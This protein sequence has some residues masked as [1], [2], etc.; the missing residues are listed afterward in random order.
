VNGRGL[1]TKDM[2][3]SFKQVLFH[4]SFELDD[5]FVKSMVD[6]ENYRNQVLYNEAHGWKVH[7]IEE[8]ILHYQD[9]IL[10]LQ[11]LFSSPKV[12]KGFKLRSTNKV[13]DNNERAYSTPT[14]T[15]W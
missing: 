8:H 12:A 3:S 1:S 14:S 2:N 5:V 11:S 6:V 7:A 13:N 4:P 10:I 9:P 15:G